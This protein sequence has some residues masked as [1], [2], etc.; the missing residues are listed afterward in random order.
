MLAPFVIRAKCIIQKIWLGG[1]DWD[2]VITDRELLAQWQ[3]W[4][5]ELTDMDCVRV[6]RCYRPDSRPVVKRQLH[7]FGDAS[8]NAFGVVAYLRLEFE[9]GTVHCSFVTSK[10]RVA[11]HQTAQHTPSGAAGCSDGRPSRRCCQGRSRHDHKRDRSSGPTRPRCYSGSTV[12]VGGT[13]RSSQTASLRSRTPPRCLS[14]A[15]CRAL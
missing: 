15:T 12:R 14:G 1:W 10:A 5:Q 3:H 11:P 6:D 7:V 8:E 2:D 13:T 9:D 4:Q